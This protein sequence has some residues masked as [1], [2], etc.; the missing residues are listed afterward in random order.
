MMAGL[1]QVS[2][3]KT[4][5]HI[6]ARNIFL[7]PNAF[8]STT[9][10]NQKKGGPAVSTS[11]SSIDSVGKSLASKGFLRP[12]KSYEAPNDAADKI[13]AICTSLNI[14]SKNDYKLS[15]LEEK[16]KVLDACF[17][18]FQHSVPN[19][20]V[21]EI[22]TIAD[23]IKFYKSSVDTTVPYDALKKADLPPNLHIQ[24]QYL[25][26]NPETDTKFNGQTAFPKSSTL[27]TGLKYREKYPGHIAK[28]SFP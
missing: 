18:D 3:R 16:F 6:F 4:G 8:Y 28:R 20:Q 11:S 26:F 9:K 21:H 25:R 12:F 14:S 22:N 2:L 7:R 5:Q 17:K 27:V 24:S 23:V 1:G 13:N 19:S 10:N 15:N